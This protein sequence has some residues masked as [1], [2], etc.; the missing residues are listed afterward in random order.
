MFG[1]HLFIFL[2]IAKSIHGKFSEKNE[3]LTILSNWG[4]TLA[5][6]DSVQ[7]NVIFGIEDLG[8]GD[9][10]R[11]SIILIMQLFC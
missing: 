1:N 5:G 6:I 7:E 4:M 8:V 3:L 11:K 9:Q 10:K 2:C